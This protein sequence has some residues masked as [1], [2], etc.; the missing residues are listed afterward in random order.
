MRA[1]R[2]CACLKVLVAFLLVCSQVAHASDYLPEPIRAKVEALKA[3]FEREPT[4]R[5]NV[6]SRMHTMWQWVNLY[7]LNGGYVPVNLTAMLRPESPAPLNRRNALVMDSFIREFILLDSEPEALATVSADT[8]PFTAGSMATLQQT[9][10][11]G[12]KD[13]ERGGGVVVARHFMP[14]Y[15]RFQT[16]DPGASNYVQIESSDPGARFVV[17]SLPINGM[18]GGF[19]GSAPALFFRLEAGRLSQG[20]TVTVTY[21]ARGGGGDGFQMPSMSSDFLP[22]PLYQVFNADQQMYSL[23]IQ[24]IR[25]QG[26][27]VAGVHGFAPSVVRPGEPFTLSVRAQDRFYN[28]AVGP[29]PA[30]QVMHGERVVARFDAGEVALQTAD[31]TFTAPGV[32]HLSIQSADGS[33]VG[34]VNPILVSTDAQR[35]F[36][37]DTHGHSGF[38]EGIGTPERFMTWA[39]E[40]ARLDFVTHSE[41]DIWMDDHEW[42]V[43]RRN[44]EAYTEPG[45]FVAYLGYEW[46]TRNIFGGHHNVLFRTP[47]GR[48]RVPTQYFPVL[49]DL[50]QG[51]RAQN[52]TRDVIVIPHAHQASDYRLNDPQLEPLVEIMSQHGTF[53]WFGRMYLQQGHQVGFTAASDNHLSQPGF[54]APKGGG[55]SQRGGLGAV[56]ADEVTVDGLFDAMKALRAYATTGERIILDVAL[57]G[58][59]MGQRI[60]FDRKRSLKGRVI[61]SAPIADIAVVRNDEVI[62]HKDY[63]TLQDGRYTEEEVF[64]LSFQSDSRPMHRGDNPRGWRPWRGELVVEGAELLAAEPTDF[65]A[66]ERGLKVDADTGVVQFA[67]SSRGDASSIRL[68]L[69]NVSN[70][71]RVH[72]RLD[73]VKEFGSGPPMFRQP[74]V[75]PA[76]DVT[77][78]LRDLERG[79]VRATLPF[80]VYEDIV[81]LRRVI[82]TGARDI[83]FEVQDTGEIQGDYYYVRVQQAD[84]A[85]AWSSPIWVGGYPK[86]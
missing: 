31:L 11:I 3:D 48:D 37:G 9:L 28:R 80:D 36:W 82:T 61:G 44:V 58:S 66:T 68:R 79:K 56:L 50:Y 71:T 59:G 32:V 86:R 29:I 46:T 12:T 45:R 52:A 17:D 26:D 55:L 25:I 62:W 24:P 73:E 84:D 40:D 15:G 78:R 51:L 2:V 70:R 43:L 33:I 39:K 53:E 47:Q 75:L 6:Q 14:D 1:S 81:Q 20:E 35:V 38:A 83:S 5:E 60:P 34:R 64:Y 76:A 54:T 16:T 77:L 19:R 4:N 22:F 41:H 65:V 49:S 63:L 67:T 69:R 13:I 8:G 27:A 18:H 85:A 74:A 21:G 72:V 30:W 7:A 57:N 42:E 10:T 23:P